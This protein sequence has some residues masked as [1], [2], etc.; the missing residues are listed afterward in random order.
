[1]GIYEKKVLKDIFCFKRTDNP[2][3]VEVLRELESSPVCQSLAMHSFLMLPMQRITRSQ[4]SFVLLN[5][6]SFILTPIELYQFQSQNGFQVT[7]TSY[8]HFQ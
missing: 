6:T 1:M 3:F 8:C 5:K 2:K 7:I 4:Q